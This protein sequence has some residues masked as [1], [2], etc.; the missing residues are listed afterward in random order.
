ME[1]NETKK[2]EKKDKRKGR[3]EGNDR[4]TIRGNGK[5]MPP[6]E[7]QRKPSPMRRRLTMRLNTDEGEVY[8]SRC[9]S[10]KF[11]RRVMR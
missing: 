11:S 6:K 1:Q 7:R 10:R 3:K 9:S 2:D 4:E 8:F 5:A